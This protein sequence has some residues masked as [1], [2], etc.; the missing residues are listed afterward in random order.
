MSEYRFKIGGK[1]FDVTVGSIDKSKA[2]VTVNGVDYEVELEAGTDAAP[3][4]AAPSPAAPDRKDSSETQ[5][6]PAASG[7]GKS[8]TSPLPGV[9]VDICVKEGQAVGKGDRIAVLEAMK[10]E[11]DILAPCDGT[12]TGLCV[13]K[14]DSVLEGADIARIS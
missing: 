11:N 10:M 14:G 3:V 6:R 7:T 12:I 9:I 5:Q 13:A 4:S 8:V 1:P 2:H